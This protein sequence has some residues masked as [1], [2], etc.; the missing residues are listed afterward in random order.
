MTDT[1]AHE[2][3]ECHD[4]LYESALRAK[5]RSVHI[6]QLISTR[7][8]TPNIT[9][10]ADVSHNHDELRALIQNLTGRFNIWTSNIGVFAALR[11]SMDYRLRDAPEVHN[12]VLKLL[13]SLRGNLGHL[14]ST[15]GDPL[16]GTDKIPDP[17]LSE[18]NAQMLDVDDPLWKVG[19][20]KN[21][22]KAVSENLVRLNR[23]SNA[24]HR[25]G[26]DSRNT[27]ASKFKWKDEEGND[28]GPAWEERFALELCKRK[29][30]SCNE[31]IQRRL[32]AA[33]LTR[34]KRLMYRQS[35]REKLALNTSAPQRKP[36]IKMDAIPN[37]KATSQT[38]SKPAIAEDTGKIVQNLPPPKSIRT[39]DTA[40]T[41][42]DPQ[43]MHHSTGV[44]RISTARSVPMD[45][46]TR[47][48]FPPNPEI[49]GL[50]EIVC[51]Y[52]CLVL[53]QQDLAKP[54]WWKYVKNRSVQ[55]QC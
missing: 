41:P 35:R 51:P 19:N 4:L 3:R 55:V 39:L 38:Q 30:P 48:H 34:R 8:D 16:Q 11:L 29:Y 36:T 14:I 24:I 44:S 12:L 31:I 49:G 43:K 9:T 50:E 20:I 7:D 13:K 40:A 53:R 32:A 17:H 5:E 37:T 23:L 45:D 27:R 33:M 26:T 10:G 46:E 2:A 6:H 47:L 22:I 52:C 54:N 18:G 15:L 42:F 28:I 25:A 1:I 21:A